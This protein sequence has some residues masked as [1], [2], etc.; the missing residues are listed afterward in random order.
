M[1]LIELVCV[2]SLLGQPLHLLGSGTGWLRP[3]GEKVSVAEARKDAP[4]ANTWSNQPLKSHMT[5]EYLLASGP[6]PRH[7]AA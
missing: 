4:T 5:V 7:D 1:T 6:R 3:V 2:H